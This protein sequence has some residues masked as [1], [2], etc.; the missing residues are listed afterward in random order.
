MP[1]P[2][3]R[4]FNDAEVIVSRIT[5]EARVEACQGKE[6]NDSCNVSFT[7]DG[8][9]YNFKGYCDG[10]DTRCLHLELITQP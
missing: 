3:S 4:E 8:V 2:S 5:K 6:R 1:E 10:I 9:T 7:E